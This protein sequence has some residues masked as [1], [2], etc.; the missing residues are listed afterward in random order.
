M[1]TSPVISPASP[2]VSPMVRRNLD[3]AQYPLAR[4]SQYEGPDSVFP[5][6][7]QIDEDGWDL[8][9]TSPTIRPE[10]VPLGDEDEE[11]DR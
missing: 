3:G 1:S 10:A 8:G 5:C 4:G 7:E 6:D 11:T 2:V 9:P